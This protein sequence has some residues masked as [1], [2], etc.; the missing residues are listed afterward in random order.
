MVREAGTEGTA[1]PAWSTRLVV[2][3][4]GSSDAAIPRDVATTP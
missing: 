3:T 1:E 4:P 2:T